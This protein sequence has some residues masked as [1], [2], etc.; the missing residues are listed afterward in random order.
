MTDET[1]YDQLWHVAGHP[2]ARVDLLALAPAD[3]HRFL[4]IARIHGVL[5]IVLSQGGDITS[6]TGTTWDN[7][8]RAWKG[9]VIQSLRVRH[10]AQTVLG[11][12]RQHGIAAV[13]FKGPDFAEHLYPDARLRPTLDVD[14]L[15]PREQW[16]QALR[17]LEALG[18][19]EKAG[20]PGPFT[21]DGILS[22]RTWIFP[23]PGAPIEV[24]M[25][26]S[27]VHFPYFR[28]QAAIDYWNLDWQWLPGSQGELTAASRLVI[29]AVHAVYHHQF[30]RLLE[31]VD[32]QKASAKVDTDVEQQRA[33]ALAERTGTK[34]ALDV[35]L[36]VTARFLEDPAVER[37]RG[38]LLREPVPWRLPEGLFQDARANLRSIRTSYF[39]PGTQ[40]IRQWLMQQRM[41]P[42]PGWE[43]RPPPPA[44]TT[45][46]APRAPGPAVGAGP[47]FGSSATSRPPS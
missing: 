21:S 30:D 20:Q 23:L 46:A 38:A 42:Q 29:A 27:L 24:D 32:V 14:I 40:R 25:H 45:P 22:Q 4:A 6:G 2:D 17:A 33:R 5:G 47:W 12:L 37:T 43:F 36:Q 3:L 41:R 7:V 9:Q 39:S 31:L 28:R 13:Q 15:V 1:I 19:R 34:L 8:R 35:A 44:G 11:A 16:F 10:H 18:H 26:W